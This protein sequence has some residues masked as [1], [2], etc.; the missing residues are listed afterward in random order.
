MSTPIRS[1]NGPGT[2]FRGGA[3][4]PGSRPTDV[5]GDSFNALSAAGFPQPG[6][7]GVALAR[8]SR[9]SNV[10]IPYARIAP[11]HET[12]KL[13]V[14]V[15]GGRDA[16]KLQDQAEYDGLQSGT[17][18]WVKRRG[19]GNYKAG[20]RNS[21][22][23]VGFGEA[24]PEGPPG[25]DAWKSMP[26]PDAA[27]RTRK[28]INPT[29]YGPDRMQ[30]MAS[31]DWMEVCVQWA[32]A[33][34]E[35]PLHN[36]PVGIPSSGFFANDFIGASF[37]AAP[38]IAYNYGKDP[39]SKT[40][41][42]MLNVMEG[43]PAPMMQGFNVM[44]KGPFL[45]TY[46][47][48]RKDVLIKRDKESMVVP[49]HAGSVLVQEAFQKKLEDIGLFNW[50]P[51]GV[52]LSKDETG[53]DA[54][55]DVDH[56]KRMGQLFNIGVQ[57]PCITTTWSGSSSMPVLPGD[58]VFVLVVADVDYKVESGQDELSYLKAVADGNATLPPGPAATPA[59]EARK[60]ALGA[61]NDASAYKTAVDELTAVVGAP[62]RV[63]VFEKLFKDAAKSLR[64]GTAYA[65]A[66]MS[67]FRLMR[68]T[69]SQLTATSY[70]GDA[71]RTRLAYGAEA[72]CGL[73]IGFDGRSS[74]GASYIVGGWC[75]G[76]VLDAAASRAYGAHGVRSSISSMAHNINVNIEWWDSDRLHDAYADVS[77]E[78]NKSTM[79]MRSEAQ[80]E[81]K[82]PSTEQDAKTPSDG[83]GW[84]AVVGAQ[85]PD[86]SNYLPVDR[87][88]AAAPKGVSGARV[89][90]RG[91]GSRR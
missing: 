87:A 41:A 2:P 6:N 71:T 32:T 48:E 68:A 88:A 21:K 43:V 24:A 90:G 23:L 58:K 75:I 5:R 17:L 36:A 13:P 53:P 84:G 29:G 28:N 9:G 18:A 37:L 40:V 66:T 26:G 4:A 16:G 7:P 34:V 64:N 42:Q 39:V 33:G 20:D 12:A 79:R 8:Q 86:G 27:E 55:A 46:G 3:Y 44:E 83:I 30:R 74:G 56:D 82:I 15:H 50:V 10:R 19:G 65:R 61:A 14:P 38:D 25:S 52:C 63:K 31:T 72:R 77:D 78:D 57:G 49:R 67:G 76:T 54:F 59:S 69:S 51:D 1:V 89:A 81:V 35:I 70:V 85:D 80:K 62:S 45:T 73:K 91:G 60:K 22:F 11:M 47:R